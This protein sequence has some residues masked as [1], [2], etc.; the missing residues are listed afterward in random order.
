MNWLT[1]LTNKIVIDSLYNIQNKQSLLSQL[2]LPCSAAPAV[3]FF[4][5]GFR[6]DQTRILCS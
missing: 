2:K 4:A 6:V 5:N 1:K 3:F